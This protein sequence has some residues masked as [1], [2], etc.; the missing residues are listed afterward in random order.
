MSV[1]LPQPSGS[2]KIYATASKEWVIPPKLKPGRKPK[3]VPQDDLDFIENARKKSQNR[4]AQRAFRERRQTQ[5]SELQAR[6]K[7]YEQGEIERS[8]T[9]QALGIRLKAENDALKEQNIKLK[10][11]NDQLNARLDS[12]TCTRSAAVSSSS[13]TGST[14][15]QRGI[16]RARPESPPSSAISLKRLRIADSPPHTH[17]SSLDTPSNDSTSPI[18]ENGNSGHEVCATQYSCG[19]CTSS[20]DCICRQLGIETPIADPE[21]DHENNNHLSILDNLP[22]YQPAVPLRRISKL[23]LDTTMAIATSITEIDGT[24]SGCSGDPKNCSACQDSAFGRAFCSALGNSVCMLNPCPTCQ[25]NTESTSKDPNDMDVDETNMPLTVNPSLTQCCGDPAHCKGGACTPSQPSRSSSK[26]TRKSAASSRERVTRRGR[27]RI[28]PFTVKT[29]DGDTVPCDVVWKALEAH[30]NAH[31]ANPAAGPSHLANLNLLADVVARRSYC[32]LA[33]G[34]PTPEPEDF[35]RR[36]RSRPHARS[37]D[38]SSF[39]SVAGQEDTKVNVR[40]AD[41]RVEIAY[42]EESIDTEMQSRLMVPRE[43]LQG[44]QRI[45]AVPKEGMRDA[46]ALLDQQFGCS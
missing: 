1:S 6:I 36:T 14:P 38:H 34:E 29:V 43:V 21:A 30:P 8:V 37:R 23:G 42:E 5:L 33:P 2:A 9:L 24:P 18:T 46:I 45:T 35:P 27:P 44:H 4:S 25:A 31:L 26:S 3:A 15:L 19:M 22:P 32:T 20:M 17:G 28:A 41:A 39:S 16:K 40:Q 10:E 7:Q 12:C 13:A 11:E